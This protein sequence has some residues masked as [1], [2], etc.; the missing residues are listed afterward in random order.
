M[1]PLA[2]ARSRFLVP[3]GG[4][5]TQPT[6]KEPRVSEAWDDV[7]FQLHVEGQHLLS[8]QPQDVL[9]P[10]PQLGDVHGAGK[11]GHLSP[12]GVHQ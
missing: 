3:Q 11:G 7:G 6:G 5:C 2:R 8:T 12:S 4:S 10:A 1:T 9:G